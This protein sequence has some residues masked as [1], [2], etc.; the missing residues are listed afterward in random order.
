VAAQ[1]IFSKIAEENPGKRIVFVMAAPRH[2][3]YDGT[4]SESRV[5]LLNTLV[6][7]LCGEHGFEL[8]DLTEPMVEN[9]ETNRTKFNS[10]WDGHW[11]EYGHEI[12]FRQVLSLSWP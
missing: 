3:I 5:R 6:A 2:A 11:N 9:F 12:V 7:Q 8:I 1:Y 10:P 4:A